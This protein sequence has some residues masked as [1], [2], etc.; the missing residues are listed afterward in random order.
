MERD[1]QPICTII[2][3]IPSGGSEVNVTARVSLV[4]GLANGKKL[5]LVIPLKVNS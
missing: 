1:S 3:D 4:D 5:T 2:T